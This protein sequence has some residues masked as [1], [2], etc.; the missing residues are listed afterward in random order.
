M[1]Q[2]TLNLTTA[3]ARANTGAKW[4]TD[5]PGQSGTRRLTP[6]EYAALIEHYGAGYRARNASRAEATGWIAHPTCTRC[7]YQD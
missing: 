7:Y 6:E 2:P 1:T 5:G 3:P 4:H